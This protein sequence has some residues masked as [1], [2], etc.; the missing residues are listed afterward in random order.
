MPEQ[1][2]ETLPVAPLT[3]KALQQRMDTEQE[4]R[5][6]IIWN[7]Y[8]TKNVTNGIIKEYEQE[9]NKTERRI[10]HWYLELAQRQLAT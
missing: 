7:S 1:S 6:Q 3:I 10:G 4:I 8:E 2:W 9:F 5:E